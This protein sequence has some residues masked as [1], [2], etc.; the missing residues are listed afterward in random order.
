MREGLYLL[1]AKWEEEVNSAL[2]NP[3]II[4]LQI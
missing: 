4:R 1:I 2:Y 3:V